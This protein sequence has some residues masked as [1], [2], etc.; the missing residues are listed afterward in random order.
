VLW[1][2]NP[3]DA[4]ATGPTQPAH[5]GGAQ[6][7]KMPLGKEGWGYFYSFVDDYDGSCFVA[8]CLQ[9]LLASVGYSV[10]NIRLHGDNVGSLFHEN[11][12]R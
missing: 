9:N 4:S 2:Q 1:R 12:N 5:V 7:A 3:N 8:G 10:P 11:R 6:A